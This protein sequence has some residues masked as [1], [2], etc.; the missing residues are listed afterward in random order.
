MAP[1]SM[2]SAKAEA[3][4]TWYSSDCM[5]SRICVV[6]TCCPA[7]MASMAGVPNRTIASR[8]AR[9]NPA[10]RAG[11]TSGKVIPDMV[12]SVPAP[13]ILE[14]SSRSEGMLLNPAST[15]MNTSGI[16]KSTMAKITPVMVKMLNRYAS[17][18]P[19]VNQRYHTL[20]QPSRGPANSTQAVAPKTAG[21]RKTPVPRCG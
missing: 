16:T 11:S 9:I 1:S 4:P 13:A 2:G 21:S 14:A 5:K 8:N 12:R 17:S 7:G 18:P 3:R 15:T 20:S 6:I 19:P 10:N